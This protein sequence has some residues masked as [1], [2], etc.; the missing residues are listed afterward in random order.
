M[1]HFCVI[2]AI[3]NAVDMDPDN[4]P[5]MLE[6]LMEPYMENCCGTPDKKYEVLRHGDRYR[7]SGRMRVRR[8]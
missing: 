3:N 5:R 2:V 6:N 7:K 1:S 8:E 4:V